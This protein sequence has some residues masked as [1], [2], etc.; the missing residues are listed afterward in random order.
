MLE[1]ALEGSTLVV[2]D[3]HLTGIHI[4]MLKKVLQRLGRCLPDSICLP[5]SLT[6]L[7]KWAN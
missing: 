2:P 1:I 6:C 5:N 3:V 7:P 4:P